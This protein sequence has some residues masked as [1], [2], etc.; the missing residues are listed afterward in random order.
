MVTA[1]LIYLV[2][3]AFATNRYVI[4]GSETVFGLFKNDCSTEVG[5]DSLNNCTSKLNCTGGL[6][7]GDFKKCEQADNRYYDF[8]ISDEITRDIK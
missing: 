2:I 8:E 5:C 1:L 3:Q 6:D 4:G 7:C